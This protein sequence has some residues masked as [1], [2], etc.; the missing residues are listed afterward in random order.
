MNLESIIQNVLVM[1][2]DPLLL[3]MQQNRGQNP[4]EMK[5]LVQ[6]EMIKRG[7]LWGGFHN[8]SFSHSDED[9]EY[10]LKAYQDVLPIL[11]EAVDKRDVRGFLKGIRLNLYSERQATLIQSQNKKL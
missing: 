8:M 10:T 11:K 9:V 2:A 5:S 1:I 6:Q 3:L 7:I 4:L